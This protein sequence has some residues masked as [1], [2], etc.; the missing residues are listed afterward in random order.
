[1]L[2]HLLYPLHRYAGLRWLNVLR[3]IS[4]RT[5]LAMITALAIGLL[6]GPWFIRRL[7]K[8]QIGEKVREDGPATHAKKAGTPTMGGTL[9]LAGIVVGTLLWADLANVFVWDTLLVTVGFGAIGFVDDYLKLKRSKK[10]LAGRIKLLATLLIALTAMVILFQY[11]G[12]FN[13]E[14]RFRV[15]LPLLKGPFTLGWGYWSGLALYTLLGVLVVTGTSHAVNLTDGLDGLAI[16]PVIIAAGT[17]LILTYAAGAVIKGFNVAEYLHIP[18]IAGSGELAIFCGAMVG[19]GV[20]FLWYNAHPAQ[21]FMGDVG[22]LSL[23]GALGMLAVASKNEFTLL[24]MGGVFVAEA[25]SVMM[26]VAYFKY[27]GGRRIFLMTPLHHHFE[28]KGWAETKVT[29]RFWIV[30]FALA[31]IALATLKVR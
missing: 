15:S 14:M 17:F 1:M 4:T 5:L 25:V 31:L 30:A 19:A 18:F 10:G 8:L 2:Y 27:T 12:A 20:G 16:G 28:K 24:I 23:G 9:I 21:V 3:Y 29:V 13:D 26:Q 11:P 6:L 22:A 7:Q